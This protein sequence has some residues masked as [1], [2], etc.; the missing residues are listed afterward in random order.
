MK[1]FFQNESSLQWARIAACPKHWVYQSTVPNMQNPLPWNFEWLIG[2]NS[3]ISLVSKFI[4]TI[5]NLL[6][7]HN[8]IA[9]LASICFVKSNLPFEQ[10]VT[11]WKAIPFWKVKLLFEK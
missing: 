1:Y 4:F 2:Q 3:Q 10:K 11:F 6:Y 5:V 9:K 7:K 8:S